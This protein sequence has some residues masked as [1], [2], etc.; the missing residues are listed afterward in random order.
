MAGPATP[1]RIQEPRAPVPASASG[2]DLVLVGNPNVGKSVLFGCLTNTYVTVSNYPGTTVEISRSRVAA[3]MVPGHA[4][5]MAVDTPGTN[6]LIPTSEDEKVTRDILLDGGYRAVVQVGDAKNLRRLLLLSVQLAEMEIPMVLCLNMGDEAAARGIS[7]DEEELSQ[8]LGIPCISTVAVRR[9]GLRE[10][11]RALEAPAWPA[12]RVR[13][14]E[15]IEEGIRKIIPLLPETAISPR[16]L[17]L[18]ILAGDETLAE[19]LHQSLDADTVTR[20]REIAAA[21]ARLYGEPVRAVISRE[22]LAAV[23]RVAGRVLREGNG[24]RR[25]MARWLERVTIHPVWGVPVLLAVLWLAYEFVGVFGAGIAVDFIE[26]TLFNGYINPV[27]TWFFDSFVPVPLVRDFF[28]GDYGVVTMALTYALAIILPIVTTFFLAFGFLEDSGYLPRLAVMV[29]R[30]FRLM[31]L[32][33]KAVLPMVLGLGCDTMATLTT[34]ILESRKERLIVIVLLALGVPCSAQLGVILAM[35]AGLS[36]QATLIWV[37]TVMG[38]LFVVGW[39]ASRAIPGS[40]SEF[41]LELPPIRW[42]RLGNIMVKTLGRMEWYLKEAAPLFVL[43]TV[44][45]FVADRTGLLQVVERASEPVIVSMLSLPA[46]TAEVFIIGFLRRDFGAA[47]LLAMSSAGMLD[48]LQVV[49]ALVTITLFI[50]CIANFFMIIKERGWR[51]AL[52]IACFIF[53]LALLVGA[54]L[55]WTLRGLGVGL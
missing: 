2:D 13:H 22:R 21:T 42:P 41:I 24:R 7:I 54:G 25:P 52:A 32:N 27:A 53:P 49:V 45:L 23:E 30:I 18:M 29:N 5:A 17:A 9:H 35:L 8:I 34:R 10:L 1:E 14:S 11:S 55:N 3:G 51:T 6:T 31:G 4:D 40:G 46:A 15:A 50:P 39:L 19:W 36:W 48:P 16:S 37:G 47:G 44:V 26:E 33:G 20:L 38:T 43:G 12:F 28:V